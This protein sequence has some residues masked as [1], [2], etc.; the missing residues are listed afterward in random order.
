MNRQQA[1]HILNAYVR[2]RMRECDKDV[3]DVLY[4]VILDAMTEYKT[5]KP[6]WSGFGITV[7]TT[8][9]PTDWDGTPKV[10]CASIDPA[11]TGNTKAVDA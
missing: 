3:S 2:M 4:E 10:T 8:G 5:E 1:A 11:F 9:Y 7:P 6:G